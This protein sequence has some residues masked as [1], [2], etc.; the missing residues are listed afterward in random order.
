MTSL[1][2]KIKNVSKT[3]YLFKELFNNTNFYSIRSIKL[4]SKS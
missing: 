1:A 4:E 2:F 3:K